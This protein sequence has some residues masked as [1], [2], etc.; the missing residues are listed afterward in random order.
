MFT[1][2]LFPFRLFLFYFVNSADC[3]HF[4]EKHALFHFSI[5]DVFF[6]SFLFLNSFPVILLSPF[7][8]LFVFLF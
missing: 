5:F 3:H 1:K 2:L 8:W 4:V 6:S 7:D